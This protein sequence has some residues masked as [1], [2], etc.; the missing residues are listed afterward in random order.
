MKACL[1]GGRG[2]N[3]ESTAMEK[4]EGI[5]KEVVEKSEWVSIATVGP[6]GPHLAATWGVY[7][8]KLG[9]RDN[10]ILIPAGYLHKTEANLKQNP[11]IEL[12]FAS[13]QVQ[14]NHGPGR[15]CLVAGTGEVQTIG[16][17]ATKVKALFPWAR[18]VLVVTIESAVTQL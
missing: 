15:G 10:V 13:R 16:V 6:E 7:I 18:G 3:I 8:R 1:A 5:C 4:I 9:I 17:T 2:S 14:G 12:L 11:R